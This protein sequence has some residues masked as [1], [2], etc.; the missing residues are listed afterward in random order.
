MN[1]III[2]H[3]SSHHATN[4][5]YA[6]II[7]FLPKVEVVNGSIKFPYR[8]AKLISKNSN[9]LS[10]NYDTSSVL[11]EIELFKHLSN[12]KKQ[13]VHY[14]NAERDIRHLINYKQFFKNTAFCGTFH[15]PASILKEQ[16]SN[17]K[18]LKK[19]DGAIA[20]GNNQVDFLKNWLKI[21]NVKYIPHG[22]D[23]YFFVP[24][25]LKKT[26][27]TLLFVG[28]HLRD[29]DTFNY[30]I[31]KIA[32]QIKDLKVNVILRKEYVKQIQPHSTITIFNGVDDVAL[33]A[34]YQQAS[35]LFL[36]LKDVTACNSILEAMACGLPIVT[37][38]VGGNTT[39]I[40]DTKN[41]LIPPK[42]VDSFIESVVA[43]LK[44]E[45]ELKTIGNSSRIKS[46][47]YDWRE[48]AKQIEM[49]YESIE[50]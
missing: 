35:L 17:T 24:D 49:Y 48:I 4:S 23:T 14:L 33:R 44:N 32:E 47:E 50:V 22:V 29:F 6:R 8:V 40:K 3:R 1:P 16:I 42:D 38:D 36:P 12:N 43:L 7:D 26:A 27:H 11:K 25:P 21:E 28:Q 34:L 19:L 31:P 9:Q 45:E 10:G 2:H 46:L 30:C 5:G 20:V 15:K 37:S 18:Y 39:Y 41:L 13:L